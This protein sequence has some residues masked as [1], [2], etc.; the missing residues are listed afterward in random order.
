METTTQDQQALNAALA[1]KAAEGDKQALV[2]LWEQNKG[3]VYLLT[4]RWYKANAARAAAHGLT[5]E[6]LEQ[7]GY[8]ALVFAAKS[9][10]AEKG[11]F[12][13]WLALAV[14][15]QIALTLTGAHRRSVVG[16]DG[17][18]RTVSADPL[19]ACTSLDMPVSEDEGAA[20]LGDLQEDPAGQA[21]LEAV[22]E[23]LFREELRA[24][25]DEAL[26][27]LSPT[28]AEAIRLRYYQR[29]AVADVGK[30]LDCSNSHSATIMRRALRKLRV[31][32]A[33][34]KWHDEVIS[35]HALQ[36]V[37]FQA[38]LHGGAVEERTV[39]YLE[40]RG[41]YI[42]EVLQEAP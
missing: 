6:D 25:I 19:N 5:C 40:A 21:E 14:K 4:G 7:E 24:A 12:S 29:Q 26:S 42:K 22:D 16:V 10:A 41:A 31:N 33:L 34:K 1:A 15:K 20:T 39:E 28:E 13:S 2:Q 17:V 36:G 8:F 35:T 9:Y 30:V 11:P 27:K 38:W 3:L 37:G 32:P 23:S 18:R